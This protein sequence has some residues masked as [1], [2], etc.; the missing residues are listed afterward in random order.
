MV[1]DL[2]DSEDWIEQTRSKEE[3][4]QIEERLKERREEL[5][6]EDEE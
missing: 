6:M 1:V 3:Q 5:G 2:R 4:E